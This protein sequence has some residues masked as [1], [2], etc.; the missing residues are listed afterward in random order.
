M[1]GVEARKKATEARAILKQVVKYLEENSETIIES[2]IVTLE[3]DIEKS[4]IDDLKENIINFKKSINADFEWMKDYAKIPLKKIVDINN[5]KY[6]IYNNS[7]LHLAYCDFYEEF[8]DKIDDIK[9]SKAVKSRL[10]KLT[11]ALQKKYKCK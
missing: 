2:I 10:E 5:P 6:N 8:F 7:S 1:C 3:N 11:I 4:Y 9:K